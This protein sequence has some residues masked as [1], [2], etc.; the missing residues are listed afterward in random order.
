[1]SIAPHVVE[2]R[3]DV[4]VEEDDLFYDEEQSRWRLNH[5]GM[6]RAFEQFAEGATDYSGEGDDHPRY[7]VLCQEDFMAG[8]ICGLERDHEGP[9]Q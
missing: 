3:Y 1:M 4:I 6:Q 8:Q 7:A 2:F 9:H 5:E